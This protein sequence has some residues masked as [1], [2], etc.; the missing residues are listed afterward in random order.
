MD[1]ISSKTITE[2]T[3][4]SGRKVSQGS[5]FKNYGQFNSNFSVAI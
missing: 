2:A 4:L 1:V 5:S 3:V